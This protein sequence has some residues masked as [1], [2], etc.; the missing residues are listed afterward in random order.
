MSSA[1]TVYE[2]GPDGLLAAVRV[3]DEIEAP[4]EHP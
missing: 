4:V 3:Y 1:A 2:R